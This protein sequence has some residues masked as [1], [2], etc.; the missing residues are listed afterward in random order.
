MFDLRLYV[1]SGGLISYGADLVDLWRQSAL[2]IDQTLK[3]AKPAGLPVEQ[4]TRFK[5]V[6]N[7][8]A[9]NAI[10]VAARRRAVSAPDMHLVLGSIRQ[11]AGTHPL[12][13]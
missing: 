1:D 2:H 10:G 9:A 5:L 11:R 13:R 3:G 6:I 7:L 8:K 12:A 4:P